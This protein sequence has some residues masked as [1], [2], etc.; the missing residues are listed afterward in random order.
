[1]LPIEFNTFKVIPAKAVA[2]CV[3]TAISH[4]D[5]GPVTISLAQGLFD[6]NA[7]LGYLAELREDLL[8]NRVCHDFVGV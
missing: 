3:I 7:R 8:F 6:C 5:T 4:L 2:A 1:M